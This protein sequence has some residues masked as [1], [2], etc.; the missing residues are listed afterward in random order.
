MT[1]QTLEQL[2]QN[3]PHIRLATELDNS[4][5]LEFYHACDMQNKSENVKYT[6]G[7]DFFSFLK[8]RSSYNL[9]FTLW[10]SPLKDNQIMGIGA[11]SF[12]QGHIGGKQTTVGYLGDLRVTLSRKLIREWRNFYTQLIK[13]S[14]FL[15]E[16][17]NCRYYQTVLMHE[18]QTALVNLTQAKIKNL[19]YHLIS[20][21]R[22]INIVGILKA[23]FFSR[24]FSIRHATAADREKLIDFLIKS[25]R[26]R[27]FGRY[28]ETELDYRIKHWNNF[29]C[30]NFLI[31]E[32]ENVWVAVTSIWNPI[33]TKQVEV[34]HIP[35]IFKIIIPI[36]NLIPVFQIKELP[37]KNTPIEI[38][39][40]NQL[41]FNQEVNFDKKRIVREIIPYLFKYNFNILAVFE[42]EKN[43]IF[44]C[45]KS[46]IKHHIEMGFYSVHYKNDDGTIRDVLTLEDNQ[47]DPAFDMSL[48]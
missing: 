34:S 1:Y 48:V 7:K 3:F 42:F 29:F 47:L 33:A 13:F 31:I 36:L 32:K 11:V 44:S 21:Y 26:D 6:R 18:N 16:T 37:K 43:K 2:L 5:I 38:L 24:Q 39:Y 12:R 27:I 14:P 19:D 8:E 20:N 40:L 10:D 17:K 9:V 30:E 41:H 23:P 25:D 28:W 22:M 15:P 4:A 46:F 35:S 45:Q